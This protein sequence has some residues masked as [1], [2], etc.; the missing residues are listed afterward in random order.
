MILELSTA[1]LGTSILRVCLIS[2]LSHPTGSGT[3]RKTGGSKLFQIAFKKEIPS[4]KDQ[5]DPELSDS[6]A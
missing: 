3:Q 6:S 4:K 5:S 1:F 2:I